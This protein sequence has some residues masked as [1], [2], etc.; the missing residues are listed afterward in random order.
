MGSEKGRKATQQELALFM[1][2]WANASQSLEDDLRSYKAQI[3]ADIKDHN[4]Q[5]E[6]DFED[7]GKE[8]FLFRLRQFYEHNE[9]IERAVRETKDIINKNQK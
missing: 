4:F 3:M 1:V 2:G 8:A 9:P 5:C 6:H 7:F